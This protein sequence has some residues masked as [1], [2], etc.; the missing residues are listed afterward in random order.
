M[1]IL[2]SIFHKNNH[3]NCNVGGGRGVILWHLWF[4]FSKNLEPLENEGKK[5]KPTQ[6]LNCKSALVRQLIRKNNV[7][8]QVGN[9]YHQNWYN[10]QW[11][12]LLFFLFFDDFLTKNLNLCACI[13]STILTFL[14]DNPVCFYTKN[15]QKVNFSSNFDQVV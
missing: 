9:T 12:S 5:L 14:P 11:G 13:S 10:T 4:K 2:L 6:V 15:F 8:S 1:T 3:D 7:F